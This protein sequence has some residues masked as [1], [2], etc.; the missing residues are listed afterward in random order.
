MRMRAVCIL[1]VLVGMLAPP[2]ATAHPLGNFSISHY[3]GLR[4]TRSGLELTYV[5]DMAEIPTFQEM[6]EHGLVAERGHASLPGYVARRV[7]TLSEGLVVEIDGR[8]VSLTTGA[9][10]IMFPEGAGGLPTLKLGVRYRATWDS[11]RGVVELRYRDANFPA[12]AGWKEIIAEAEEGIALVESTAPSRDRSRQLSDYPTDLLSSPP[13]DLVARVTFTV[14]EPRPGVAGQVVPHP[15]DAASRPAVASGARA[16]AIPGARRVPAPSALD[17]GSGR[18]AAPEGEVTTHETLGLEPNRRATPRGTFTDLIATADVRSGLIAAALLIAAGLG[19]LHALE[20]GHGKTVVGAYLVG[21]RGTP[22]HAVVLGL[23]VTASHTAGVY[24]LGAV[25][26]YA[27]RHVVPERLYPWL[28]VLSGL[29]IAGLGLILFVRRWSGPPHA[30]AHAHDHVHAH[31]GDRDD[32]HARAPAGSVTLGQLFALGVSGGIVPCPAALVV[33]LAA[34]AMGRVGLG[35]LL[36]VAFSAGLAAVLIA[37]GLLVVWAGRFVSRWSGEGTMVTRWL[38]LASS[39]VVAVFG[40]ALVVQSL[41][42]AGVVRI[43]LGQLGL[44]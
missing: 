40:F 9:T 26:L 24:L 42:G 32:A 43:D 35:L 2:S 22:R 6:Q 28:G 44:G 1:A 4:L 14:A 37:I 20:P 3:S 19:A 31:E 36:I 18:S 34:V 8:R 15:P 33:L 25:T 16:A 30:H 7:E 13:Q 17:V 11:P 12:R 23:I 38:P 41:A 29:I 5:I 39:A 10:D 21:Q 27:S